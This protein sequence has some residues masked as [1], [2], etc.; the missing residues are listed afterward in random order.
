MDGGAAP[1]TEICR[2][3]R[4]I[5]QAARAARM[6]PD[7]AGLAPA[8]LKDILP[9][10]ALFERT[11]PSV[12]MIR[13]AGTA[14][15]DIFG[16]EPTG[17]NLIE[18]TPPPFRRHRAFF[19]EAANH[20]VCGALL[21]LSVTFPTGIPG[22]YEVMMLPVDDAGIQKFLVAIAAT[23]G[24]QWQNGPPNLIV[25]P[26]LAFQFVDVGAGTPSSD[27]PPDDFL[28]L[29]GLASPDE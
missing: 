23:H 24:Q 3:F 22:Q 25:N 7:L 14:Y 2:Q 13:L 6:V 8:A 15:R 9:Y 12:V 17:R 19:F 27:V 26:P 4:A 5:W 11:D 1:K 28:P 29:L 10:I 20:C 18:L 21:E 16:F